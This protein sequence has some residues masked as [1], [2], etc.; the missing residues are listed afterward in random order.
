MPSIDPEM[1]QT[2]ILIDD[3][4]NPT[5][6]ASPVTSFALKM[7]VDFCTTDEIYQQSVIALVVVMM[8]PTR[9]YKQTVLIPKYGPLT[10]IGSIDGTACRFSFSV[11]SSYLDSCIT[12]SCCPEGI[13][14]LL[15]SVFFD[16][17]VSCNLVGAQ[18]T[19]V[20]EALLP[21]QGD[22]KLLLSLMTR[23]CAKLVPL[24]AAAVCIQQVQHIFKKS[25]GGTPPLGLPVA[26]WTGI[27]ES[28][29]QLRFSSGV[30]PASEILRAEEWRLTY[31]I[32][33]ERLPPDSPSPPF[34]K[35][36]VCN[37]NVDVRR[38]L[39]HD[40]KL[41]SYRM[42]WILEM[43]EKF[44][45]QASPLH[46]H[47]I[48]VDLEIVRPRSSNDAEVCISPID[49]VQKSS[50]N[51]TFNVFNW[52][53]N[54]DGGLWPRSGS[55]SSSD[56]RAMIRHRWITDEDEDLS[57]GRASK[58]T[59][60]EEPN[61]ILVQQW[62]VSVEES[63]EED[64]VVEDALDEVV[65]GEGSSGAGSSG[66]GCWAVPS[67]SG[68]DPKSKWDFPTWAIT[69]KQSLIENGQVLS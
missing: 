28:F 6:L 8:L 34:G 1:M 18:M 35:T 58:D 5:A 19:G 44:P 52:F 50:C 12:L 62:V 39:G 67:G 38:H 7:L 45:A 20:M 9:A 63:A 56:A 14:S 21:I 61:S 57:E 47:L 66:A 55:I 32:T 59:D 36:T 24:W 60:Q 2:I 51:A 15:C 42:Y 4:S 49:N 53:R 68:V 25:A 23:R 11:L 37:L 54:V 17:R 29:I 31:L 41:L 3:F 27:I 33:A 65:D 16:P 26:S 43:G 46:L 40:H 22:G 30:L 13:D 10:N 48:D 69:S 64:A